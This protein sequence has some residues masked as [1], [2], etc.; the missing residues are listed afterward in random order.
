MSEEIRN[1][2]FSLVRYHFD[3]VSMDLS[4]IQPNDNFRLTIAPSGAYHGKSGEFNLSFEFSASV[5]EKEVINIR[6]I[7]E[8]RFKEP[9]SPESFP[10]YFYANSIAIVFPYVRAFIST[11][12]L[13]ANIRPLIIPTF[14]LSGLRDELARNTTVADD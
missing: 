6:C 4:S 3:K 7:A 5:K 9:V 12:T 13:Q 8:F 2:V 14:N 1:A 11:V 10:D